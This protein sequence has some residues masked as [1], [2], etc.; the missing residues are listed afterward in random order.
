MTSVQLVTLLGAGAGAGL[1]LV[2]A[3]CTASRVDL[4]RLLAGAGRTEPTDA[5]A[6]STNPLLGRLSRLDTRVPDAELDLIGETRERFLL[7]RIA[8]AAAGALLLP[9]LAVLLVVAGAGLPVVVPVG[10]SLA[11]GVVGWF[12]PPSMARSQAAEARAV[13]RRALCSYFDLVALERQADRGPVEALEHP[14]ML[15]GS[16]AF[17]R[18]RSEM[19]RSR[20]LGEPPWQALRRLADRL[21]ID[22][23]DDLGSILT[24]S[25]EEG[26]SIVDSLTA[27][28][29][30]MRQQMLAED[31]AAAHEQNRLLDLPLSILGM[32]IVLFLVF[33][34]LYVLTTS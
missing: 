16:W 14:T 2:A 15:G 25:Q 28:A 29:A 27:K 24:L 11:G 8:F 19:E 4:G 7:L 30:S 1:A 26:A 20:R 23:L 13:V 21:G 34:G 3:G 6:P 17:R 12:L 5:P 10:L 31:M 33:P 9:V 22:E 32:S 18:L